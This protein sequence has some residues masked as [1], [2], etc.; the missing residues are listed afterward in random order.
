MIQN[1]LRSSLAVLFTALGTSLL[2]LLAMPGRFGWWPLLFVALTPL[3]VFA[4]RREPRLSFSAGMLTGFFYHAGMLYWIVI[5]LGRY[6]G[7]PPALSFPAMLLLAVYMG[8]YMALFAG[9][10]SW[11]LSGKDDGRNM[12]VAILLGAPVLWV[13]LDWL[14]SILFSGFPWMDIGYGLSSRPLL[15]QT[16]DLGGHH[17]ISFLL[18]LINALI[19][20]MFSLFRSGREP[21]ARSRKVW[22]PVSAALVFLLAAGGYSALRFKQVSRMA[23]AA[24][25]LQV[26]VVQGNISQD[27]KWTPAVKKSTLDVYRNLSEETVRDNGSTLVVWPETAL[28]FF[29]VNDPLFSM[30]TDWAAD[31]D[32][33]LLTGAP[34][35]VISGDLGHSFKNAVNYFNSALLIDP[36]GEVTGR[37]DK[38]HLVPFGEYVPLRRFLP[39]LEPLVESVGNFSFGSSAAP[40]SMGAARLG[41]LICYESIFPALAREEAAAGANVLVNVTN[42]AWYGRSSA[43]YQSFAMAVLRAVETRRSL[44]RAANTGISGFV[45]PSGRIVKKSPIF[46]PLALSSA[47]PVLEERTIFMRFGYLFAPACLFLFPLLLFLRR[48]Q[49]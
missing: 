22:G 19:V 46:E 13:G 33:W 21:G 14:R 49:Q 47:V 25:V 24:P 45:H 34:Y 20:C 26:A 40:L 16:A 6:G 1:D 15:L 36:D 17:L 37:Y 35:F 31:H 32:F 43:P 8:V 10:L 27:E 23:D 30:V 3:L 18:V 44:V 28:P 2:L 38:Q 12:P 9:L 11:F 29:P 48:R 5:V 4:A 42:D 41:I 39:F 7:L